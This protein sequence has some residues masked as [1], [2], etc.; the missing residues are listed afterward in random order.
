MSLVEKFTQ[1]LDEGELDLLSEKPVYVAFEYIDEESTVEYLF[2]LRFKEA[3][4]G[5]SG[6]CA[7]VEDAVSEVT[8]CIRSFQERHDVP[9]I[10]PGHVDLDDG[11]G[12]VTVQRIVPTTN[13]SDF[14]G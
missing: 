10:G 1:K 6:P 12:V 13:L 9:E 2:A 8:R 5:G 3:S 7:N 14:F 11:T 4:E